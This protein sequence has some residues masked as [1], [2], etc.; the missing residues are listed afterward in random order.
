MKILFVGMYPDNVNPYRNVFFRNLIY[1]M[2]DKGVECTVVSPVPITKYRRRTKLIPKK[3]TDQS[4]KGNKIEIYYPR[5]I[6]LSSK[7]ILSFNTGIW[8]EKLFNRAVKKNQNRR[9]EP[10]PH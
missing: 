6:S 5:Y 3:I 10:K 4:L 2:A 1:A 8:S 9:T 7:R